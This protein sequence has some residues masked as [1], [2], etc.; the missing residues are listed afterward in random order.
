[1][2]DQNHPQMIDVIVSL[3][4]GGFLGWFTGGCWNVMQGKTWTGRDKEK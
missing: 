1:M 3:V 4:I 2:M